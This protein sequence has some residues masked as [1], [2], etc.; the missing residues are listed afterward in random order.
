[1]NYFSEMLASG[2]TL[3]A[4]PERWKGRFTKGPSPESVAK[5][6]ATKKR[7]RLEKWLR[8]FKEFPDM[9]ATEQQLTISAK[10]SPKVIRLAMNVL[11]SDGAVMNINGAWKWIL[12]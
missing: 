3:K 8:Y 6:I 11:L 1:M 5:Q 9:T 2:P 7:L 10:Q 4:Q 12:D